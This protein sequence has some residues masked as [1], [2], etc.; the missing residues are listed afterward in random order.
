MYKREER[1]EIERRKKRSSNAKVPTWIGMW[2]S[3]VCTNYY[4]FYFWDGPGG[5]ETPFNFSF[6][7]VSLGWVVVTLLGS[8]WDDVELFPQLL[9]ISLIY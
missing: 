2:N 7:I 9:L 5:P 8:C 1:Q 6:R 3:N 4:Y